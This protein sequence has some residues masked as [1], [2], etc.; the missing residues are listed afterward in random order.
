MDSEYSKVRRVLSLYDRL[1]TGKIIY[2]KDEL[3]ARET[4]TGGTEKLHDG[5]HECEAE[6]RGYIIRVSI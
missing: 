5:H 3:N 2:L 6:K 4:Q 1:S